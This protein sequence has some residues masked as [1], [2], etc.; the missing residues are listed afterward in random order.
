MVRPEDRQ[1][2]QTI[3]ARARSIRVARGATQEEVAEW[4]ALSSQVYARL[5]RGQLLPRLSTLFRLAA[6][7]GTTAAALLEDERE[8][9]PARGKKPVRRRRRSPDIAETFEKLD[10]STQALVLALVRHLARGR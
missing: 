8:A 3:G 1:L 6:A 5:E 7:L 4:V 10:S 2:A 9:V